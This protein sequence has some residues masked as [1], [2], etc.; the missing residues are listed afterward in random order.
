MHDEFERASAN[1]V[2]MSSKYRPEIDGLRAI[3]VVP[4]MFFHAKFAGFDSGF[5]GVDIFFV[6]SGF[7]ITKIIIADLQTGTFSVG[8]FYA[9]RARRIL[10]A[11]VSMCLAVAVLGWFLS[12]PTAYAE[13]GRVLVSVGLFAANIYYWR[14]SG[15]WSPDADSDPLR[16]TWSLSVEEQF[17]I[18]FPVLLLLLWPLG[19]KAVFAAIA[20]GAV[21][22]FALA[23][24]FVDTREWFVFYNLPT[25]AFELAA[26]ALATFWAFR[27][28]RWAAEVVCAAALAGL[29]VSVTILSDGRFW[30]AAPALLPVICTVA[31]LVLT[32]E[33]RFVRGILSVPVLRW[34]G[35]ISYSLYLWHQPLLAF[36][37]QVTFEDPTVP[38]A[39]ALLLLS[40]FIS[41]GSWKYIETPF[42]RPGGGMFLAARR[43]IATGGASLLVLVAVGGVM[44]TGPVN[45][46]SLTSPA[47]AEASRAASALETADTDRCD[48]FIENLHGA[49]CRRIGTEGPSV[50][51]WGDSHSEMLALGFA[52][53]NPGYRVT[54]VNHGYCPPIQ[55]GLLLAAAASDTFCHVPD[56]PAQLA[57]ILQAAEFDKVVL[58][59]RWTMYANAT[60][61]LGQLQEPGPDGAAL[62]KPPLEVL[63][64]G[65]AATLDVMD[66]AE[67][68]A[69]QQIPDLFTLTARERY[70]GTGMSRDEIAA[71]HATADEMFG[72]FAEDGRLTYIGTHD[73]FC[74]EESCGTIV[75]GMNV[76]RDDNHTNAAG[77]AMLWERIRGE[78]EK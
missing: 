63:R 38:V 69:L 47:A 57:E 41:W 72:A 11:L 21:A 12:T 51:F 46:I 16:H 59:S 54:I 25:R 26:G 35:L 45:Y 68:Y 36:W 66:G 78:F 2:L 22:S 48:R 19:R 53:E 44:V 37:R 70:F 31:L 17:Y 49:E 23:L 5:V 40:T 4:V 64:D 18:V 52:D 13:I 55:T 67:V 6:I 9:R 74:T 65:L 34:I 29:L 30:P 15:Y 7:L 32:P 24:M 10:P 39:I 73:I 60:H 20:L 42:R 1:G 3:A 62:A 43:A 50:L 56:R 71:W 58:V 33:T 28:G 76:Y 8:E 14:T 27:V 77:S 61:E 75:G